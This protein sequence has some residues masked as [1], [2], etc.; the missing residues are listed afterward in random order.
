MKEVVVEAAVSRRVGLG[1]VRAVLEEPKRHERAGG[2]FF[3]GDEAALG[4]G[5]VGG[6]GEADGRDRGGRAGVRAVPNEARRGVG[7]MQEIPERLLLAAVKLLVRVVHG[8]A[9]GRVPRLHQMEA[10]A[11]WTASA[12]VG[13]M[14][15]ASR[16]TV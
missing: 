9:D 15:T 12:R 3:P 4:G 7:L 16:R 14:W 13:W 5:G 8:R 11:L 10:T 2:R 1:P 6:Q